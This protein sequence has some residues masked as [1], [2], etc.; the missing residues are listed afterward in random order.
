MEGRRQR[1]NL[2]KAPSY[3]KPRRPRSPNDASGCLDNSSSNV[4][5]DVGVRG[6]Q[7]HF[8]RAASGRN[9]HQSRRR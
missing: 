1:S 6:N 2:S 8:S 7:N 3:K 9:G 5:S 4:E